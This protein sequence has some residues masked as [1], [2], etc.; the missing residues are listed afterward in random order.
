MGVK[1]HLSCYGKSR[2]KLKVFENRVLWGTFGT[3]R[4]EVVGG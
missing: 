2:E 4:E 3:K 1:F